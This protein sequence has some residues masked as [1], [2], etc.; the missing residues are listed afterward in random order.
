MKDEIFLQHLGGT[1]IG[2]SRMIGTA[3]ADFILEHYRLYG[4]PKP[5][6]LDH[7]GINDMFL[8][9]ASDVFYCPQGKGLQLTGAD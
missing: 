4:G 3:G 2:Y 9:K 6:P 7:Q 8:E 5:P 1:R